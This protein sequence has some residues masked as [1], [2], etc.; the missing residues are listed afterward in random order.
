[1]DKSKTNRFGGLMHVLQQESAALDADSTATGSAKPIAS[2]PLVFWVP[3]SK[4]HRDAEQDRRYFDPDELSSMARSMESVGNIDPL[5]VRLRPGTEDE[6][7]LLAGEKR[8]RAG[9]IAKLGKMLVRVF[10]VDD[11]TAADIK[12]ISNLQ[13]GDLNKWEETH[14]LMRMLCRHLEKSADEAVQLLNQA[15]NQK[16]G[17]T[18]NVVREKEWAIVEDVF[19]LSGRLT[20]ESFR[21]HRLPLLKLPESIQRV[22]QD[23]KLH[24]TKVN[25]IL[26]VKHPEQQNQLLEEA[27][28]NSLSVDDIQAKVKELKQEMQ[29][30]PDRSIEL[31]ER[32]VTVARQIKQAR[33][34]RDPVKQ[35]KLEKLLNQ[36]E[37]LL[38][39]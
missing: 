9:E 8:H 33:I 23:G 10:D 36:L 34:W 32:L 14:T 37:Q 24:Y 25:E 19:R 6:Y 28:S 29:P 5:S 4:I 15:A 27:I 1:M 38:N 18:S 35:K 21:K 16:R 3:H 22:L 13:R 20:P 31:P 17:L 7:D 39:D 30:S 26:K 2:P 11:R 12:A